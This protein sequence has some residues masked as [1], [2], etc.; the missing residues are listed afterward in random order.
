M[1]KGD[2][3]KRVMLTENVTKRVKFS[4]D[5]KDPVI[6]TALAKPHF[7]AVR[8]TWIARCRKGEYQQLSR[9]LNSWLQRGLDLVAFFQKEGQV[10]L[11]WALVSS[12]NA[13]AFCFIYDNI[14]QKLLKELVIKDDFYILSI[15]L[16]TEIGKQNRDS[17]NEKDLTNRLEKSNLL[18]KLGPEIKEYIDNIKTSSIINDKIKKATEVIVKQVLE[19]FNSKQATSKLLQ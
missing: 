15:F 2:V 9:D 4:E 13:E 16:S 7:S 1:E 14:P 3:I 19:S 18:L 5:T 12:S 8:N 10:L 11:D 6:F 17:M